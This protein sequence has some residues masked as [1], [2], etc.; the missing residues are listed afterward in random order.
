VPRAPVEIAIEQEGQQL[1][2]LGRYRRRQRLELDRSRQDR[3]ENI[4]QRTALEQ[5]PPGQH[6]VDHHTECPDVGLLVDR[7]APDLLWRHV[8][9]RSQNRVLGGCQRRRRL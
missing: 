4:R 8:A 2:D 1:S 6:L 9:G 7:E 3:R 5:T